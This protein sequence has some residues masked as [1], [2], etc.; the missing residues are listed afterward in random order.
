MPTARAWAAAVSTLPREL[1]VAFREGLVAGAEG[2][3][4][5]ALLT[6]AAL[7]KRLAAHRHRGE[8]TP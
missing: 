8:K 2:S 6:E 7:A 5:E 1:I 3:L 4:Q